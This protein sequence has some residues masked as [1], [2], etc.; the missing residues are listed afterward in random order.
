MHLVD[1]IFI[2]LLFLIQPIYGARF[3]H[4]YKLDIAAGSPPSRS[5]LYLQ[6]MAV[7]WL[8]LGALALTWSLFE[9]PV[10]ALGFVTP[11]GTGFWVCAV[12]LVLCNAYLV[13]VWQGMKQATAEEKQKHRQG[14]G[15]MEHLMPH[16]R[17]D[18]RHFV[19]ASITAG[20]VEEIVYRGFVL[21]Y[22]ALF[23]PLWVAA[24]V[25]SLIFGLGHSYQGTAGALRCGIVGLAFAT[26]YIASGSIWLPIIA[27][28]LLDVI[29]GAAVLEMLR[30][31][32][33][34]DPAVDLTPS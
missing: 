14:L 28:V 25:S 7:Q 31:R 24:I 11:A 10:N 17:Q 20:I 27:H 4:R 12:F 9:R 18:F 19:A 13:Y 22:L 26:L 30:S 3:F 29:Q 1:H 32:R 23:M 5:N 34:D 8:F 15:D 21:W 6:N 2:L 16:N 33:T